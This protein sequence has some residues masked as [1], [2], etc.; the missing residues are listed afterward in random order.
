MP[1]YNIGGDDTQPNKPPVAESRVE[2]LRESFT[3]IPLAFPIVAIICLL[4]GLFGGLL[5][6]PNTAPADAMTVLFWG[7]EVL[8]VVLII[9]GVVLFVQRRRQVNGGRL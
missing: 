2:S 5:V 8:V 3:S 4:V 6:R 9:W 7:G 1:T